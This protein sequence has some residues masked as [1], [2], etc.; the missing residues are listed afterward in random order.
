MKISNF[1]GSVNTN[2]HT[3]SSK[4][5]FHFMLKKIKCFVLLMPALY[6]TGTNIAVSCFLREQRRQG[7]L[8]SSN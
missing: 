1:V 5:T 4:M 3:V 2:A 6:I 8:G 7:L